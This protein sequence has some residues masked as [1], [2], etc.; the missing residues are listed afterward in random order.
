MDGTVNQV[1]LLYLIHHVLLFLV[2]SVWTD[3]WEGGREFSPF[4]IR[5]IDIVRGAG[6]PSNRLIFF[7][8]ILNIF[9]F[10]ILYTG[11]CK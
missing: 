3:R 1:E 6:S 10:C 5:Y 2:K 11:G 9:G 8:A 7:V 4:N